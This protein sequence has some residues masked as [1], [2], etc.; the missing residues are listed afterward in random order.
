MISIDITF[1]ASP[2]AIG[3][4]LEYRYVLKAGVFSPWQVNLNVGNIQGYFPITSTTVT[5]NDVIANVPDWQFNTT[6]QFRI[7][8]VCGIDQSE[9]LSEINGDYYIPLCPSYTTS[10]G[11][12]D[13]VSSSYP[14]FMTIPSVIGES[15]DYYVFS[16]Y[17]AAN[18][19]I[20]LTTELV[21]SSTI[22]AST[23]YQWVW[24]DNNVPGGIQMNT[25]Y[26]VSLSVA[27]NK[28]DMIDIIDCESQEITPPEC[29]TY[30]IETGDAWVLEWT[31][32]SG[33]PHTCF[34]PGPYNG[35]SGWNAC[36]SNFLLCS[37]TP[38]VGYRCSNGQLLPGFT[39]RN[40]PN[41][42]SGVQVNFGASVRLI[43]PGCSGNDFTDEI[44]WSPDYGSVVVPCQQCL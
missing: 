15:A 8:Q 32:C 1:T 17:D 26:L 6:Y 44:T 22:N 20:P 29:S 16:I 19:S 43:G 4:Y 23:P 34:S 21:Q 40:N 13:P 5:F 24:D 28:S 36:R 33:V 10:I 35:A 30:L 12:F 18:P 25:S 42:P 7:R 11:D 41:C 2:A 31:D 27:I 9:Q 3:G 37:L 14:I 38:P 39:T